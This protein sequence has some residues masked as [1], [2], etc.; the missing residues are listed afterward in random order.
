MS[1]S[2]QGKKQTTAR[3]SRAKSK[4]ADATTAKARSNNSLAASQPEKKPLLGPQAKNDLMGLVFVIVALVLLVIVLLPSNAIGAKLLSEG[5]RIIC[6]QGAVILPFLLLA[7]AVSFFL[8][9]RLSYST[10]RLILGLAVIFVALISVFAV[11]TPG[12]AADP[13]KL[14]DSKLLP[15]GGGYVGGAL[16]WVLLTLIGQAPTMIILIGLVLIGLVLIG[17]S[18]TGLVEW[19]IQSFKDRGKRGDDIP[20]PGSPLLDENAPAPS[21]GSAYQ[22]G[23]A[24]N[25]AASAGGRHSG[26]KGVLPPYTKAMGV[27]QLEHTVYR[28]SSE[29]YGED[30]AL[31]PTEL[32]SARRRLADIG[33]VDDYDFEARTTLLNRSGSMLEG[34]ERGPL[35]DQAFVGDAGSAAGDHAPETALLPNASAKK[36]GKKQT[37]RSALASSYTLPSMKLLRV[38]RDKAHTKAGAS[39]L[40]TT[41]NRLQATLEE[42]NVDG[43]VVGWIAGPTVTLYKISLGEGVRLNRITNLQSDIQLALAAEAIRIVAPIPGTSLV[44]IEIPN[45]VRNDV[46]LGDVL[47][48]A[49]DS[50]LALA[51]G[52]DVEGESIVADLSTMPHMLIGGTT[53]SGKSVAVN[54][55]IMSLLMRTTPDEVRM[56]L[57]DPKRV[58]LTL[59]KGIP[60][61]YV[62]VVT[63]AGQAASALA[64]CVAEMD[65]RLKLFEKH[66]VKNIKQFNVRAT[67]NLKKLEEEARRAEEAPES[68]DSA[69]DAAFDADN[70]DE[71]SPQATVPSDQDDD[72][73]EEELDITVE[74]ENLR[75]TIPYIVIVIDE[76]ADLMMLNGKEVETAVSRLAQLARAAGLHLIVA[77]QRPSTN[78][79]T[80]LIKANI[81][82]RI[83]FTVASGI[84]SRVILDS[85]GAEDLIGLGDM[86]FSRPEYSKPVRIQ[87]CLVSEPEIETVVE[88]WRSMGETDYHEE[89]LY[90]APGNGL[91]SG[92]LGDDSLEDDP[93]LWEAAEIVVSTRIGSTST[94]QRRLKIGYARAGRIMD[95]LEMKGVVGPPNSSKPREVLI[96]DVLDLETLRAYG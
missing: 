69:L 19:L 56:I 37:D 26:A 93:L 18:I 10:L 40:R 59:Y 48:S 17:L 6:G 66:A 3:S 89:I 51:I 2:N 91:S 86:L 96:D 58:E 78:V 42:F 83:A 22:M 14:F 76:L 8:K 67:E 88:Y 90:T 64:W 24:Q 16:A 52:K 23:P 55:I 11:L 15:Q 30:A 36:K 73:G 74:Q 20:L 35:D 61:L 7:W 54:A 27:P 70:G 63:D 29:P 84:D 79:I 65:R 31:E 43:E 50:A 1:N 47:D 68:A 34:E 45:A 71:F 49:R 53:G 85:Q 82:N 33:N 60:H 62:P 4:K 21:S 75:A 46:L 9:R 5:L 44:G 38:S 77:T 28:P 72:G 94:L 13:A 39:E 57:I 41:A 95:M 81:V 25:G 12:A 32:G 80:G 87:G 92:G